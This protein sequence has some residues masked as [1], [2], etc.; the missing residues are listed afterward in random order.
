MSFSRTGAGAAVLVVLLA[1]ASCASGEK[2]VEATSQ[3]GERLVLSLAPG[4]AYRQTIRWLI[5]PVTIYPQLACWLETPDGG[6]VGTVYVTA[7]AAKKSWVSAPPGGR[8]E[9]LPVWSAIRGSEPPVTDAISGPTPSGATMRD[10]SLAGSLR[11]GTYIAKLEV[12]RSY[13]Y[14]DRYTRDSSGVDGQPSLI[15]E[16][17]L[18]IGAAPSKAVFK[19]IGT[20]SL[21]G[22]AGRIR[23]GL[24]G[25]TTAL[26]LLEGAELS[27][28][29][30]SL[31]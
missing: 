17:E 7:K 10:S 22:S 25:L 9:A 15:Y 28:G 4:S 12:N 27:F 23:A 11:P 16:C 8:P 30:P 1:F 29:G 21:D 13:D 24:E 14:N 31:E 5:F 3:H 26:Q 2:S 20:G 19:P 6:Y 18:E